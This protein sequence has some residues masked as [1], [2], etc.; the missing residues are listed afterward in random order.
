MYLV[1]A[2]TFGTFLKQTFYLYVVLEIIEAPICIKQ[3]SEINI[4][5]RTIAPNYS[6]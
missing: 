1:R 6:Y 4:A 5:I 2:L 3:I